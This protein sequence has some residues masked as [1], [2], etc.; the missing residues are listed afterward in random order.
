MPL[1]ALPQIIEILPDFRYMKGRLEATNLQT[2]KKVC[3]ILY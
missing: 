3:I 2:P 1:S